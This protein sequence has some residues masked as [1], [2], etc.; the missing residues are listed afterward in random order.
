MTTFSGGGQIFLE[1]GGTEAECIWTVLEWGGAPPHPPPLMETLYIR[2]IPF[3]IDR[4]AARYKQGGILQSRGENYF[5][6]AV[7][8]NLRVSHCPKM[9]GG[10]HGGGQH[11]RE[12]GRPG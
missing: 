6:G 4:Q 1:W 11:S 9:M 5:V 8:R 7:S 3:R 10:T 12:G 2:Y